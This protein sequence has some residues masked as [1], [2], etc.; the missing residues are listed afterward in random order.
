MGRGQLNLSPAG[1]TELSPGRKSWVEWTNAPSPGGTT[2]FC[3]SI[4]KGA[5]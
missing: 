4:I 5:K 3:N 2:Q 1:A